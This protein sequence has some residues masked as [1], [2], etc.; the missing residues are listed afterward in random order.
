MPTFD[1]IC[2]CDTLSSVVNK[3]FSCGKVHTMM[4]FSIIN[5]A[6]KK[7]P[8]R[9]LAIKVLSRKRVAR[10]EENKT[11]QLT[12]S[13]LRTITAMEGTTLHSF[14]VYFGKTI[15][16]LSLLETPPQTCLVF[17]LSPS[18]CFFCPRNTLSTPVFFSHPL[19][20]TFSPASPSASSFS[21][22]RSCNRFR[23]I[24][25]NN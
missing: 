11:I 14:K 18:L 1:H 4:S 12:L 16:L 17:S 10:N 2:S 19:L 25:N 5:I 15:V 22:R 9:I 20:N 23:F 3:C 6:K 8:Q 7:L 13:T 24:L 21:R